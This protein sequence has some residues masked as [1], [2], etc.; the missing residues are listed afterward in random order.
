MLCLV[1]FSPVPAAE[2][3]EQAEH[4]IFLQ[5]TAERLQAVPVELSTKPV[6]PGA[7]LTGPMGI[8]GGTEISTPFKSINELF[9]YS[10]SHVIHTSIS[11]SS[12]G[13]PTINSPLLLSKK[14]DHVQLE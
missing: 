4:T 14:K 8:R 6:W 5:P 13:A 9:H 10:Y 12:G 3:K 11:R 7:F 2:R 1:S